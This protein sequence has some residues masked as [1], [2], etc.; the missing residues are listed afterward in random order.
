MG[1]WQAT[2]FQSAPLE[3]ID[4]D[5][6]VN[7]PNQAEF[8]S[9]GH[10]LF[11]NAGNVTSNGFNF[12]SCVFI[13]EEKDSQLR[14]GK[15]AKNDVVLTTRGT[16]GNAAYFD[17]SVSFDH[18][19]INSGMVILRT[20]KDA[21][22]PRFLYLFVRS[23]LFLSQVS[24]LR[25]GSAQPQLPIRDINRIIIPVPPL[26]EQRAIAHILGTLDDKIELNRRMNE[27]LEA[28]ART[29]FKSWFVDFEP[30]RA[31]AEGRETGLPK[32]IADLF[33]D[34]FEPACRDGHG[35]GRDSELG[36]VPKGWRVQTFAET[37]E[38]IG[39]GTPKTSVA[40]YW[41]GDIPWFSVVD[42]PSDTDVFVTDT[43]KMISQAGLEGSSTRLL[44]EG[45]TII[46]ARGTVGKVALVGVPMAMNQS[47]YG[48]RSL[49]D[50]HFFAYYSTRALVETLKQRCHGSVF[51]TITRDTLTGITAVMPPG[52]IKRGFELKVAPMMQRIKSNL[53]ESSILTAQRDSLLPKLLSGELRVKDA[54]KHLEKLDDA[55]LVQLVQQRQHEKSIP[56]TIDE[57]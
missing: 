1:E 19:R 34:S 23:P 38:I 14:K 37:I 15:L 55:E 52:P 54:E 42:A 43:Q 9:T 44:P 51:D 50:S 35:A 4:G 12:S 3:I 48:L 26:S 33:P 8:S 21:L 29:L 46:S 13:T 49:D 7:Y 22:D 40:E 10:C 17:D 6:G 47:C 20:A 25:T 18:I 5:R 53:R 57:L 36:E 45:S 16:V 24:A 41:N 31:K 32:E 28:M 30:V 27:T 11:L 39:G 56:V 2:T